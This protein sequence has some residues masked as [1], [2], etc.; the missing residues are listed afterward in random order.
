MSV[1][2]ATPTW[3]MYRTLVGV[4]MFCGLLI[5][6]TFQGT[7]PVIERNRAEALQRAVFAVLPSATRSE[8][9]LVTPD[10]DFVPDAEGLGDRVYAGA[11][12][13][14]WKELEGGPHAVTVWIRGE[15]L[16]GRGRA[17]LDDPDHR[18]DVFS[19]LRPTA[20]PGFGTLVE[21]AL[22]APADETT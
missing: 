2:T 13:R 22:D 6:I 4:G 1:A 8:T 20:V 5:A 16:P 12:G 9:F 18:K 17:V 10:G 3:P 19:R 14:W 21:I 15:E 11:D 7:R